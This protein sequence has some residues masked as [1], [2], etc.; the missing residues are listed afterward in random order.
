MTKPHISPSQMRMLWRCGEQYRRRYIEGERLPPGV[1]AVIGT[2]THRSIE[3]NLDHKMNTGELLEAD[4]VADAAAEGLN[5][6]WEQGV[7]LSDDEQAKGKGKVWGA[8]VDQAVALA[9]L[10]HA[11]LAP[12]IEP[13]GLEEKF[14]VSMDGYPFDLLGYIDIKEQGVIRDTKTAARA[15][16]QN[17]ADTS[18]QL[19]AYAYGYKDA[20]GELPDHL[21]L[22]YLVKTKTPKVVCYQTKRT[23]QDVAVLEAR[24]E[25]A[26]KVIESQVF[27][28]TSRSN[29]WCSERWCGYFSTCPYAKGR[30]V[31]SVLN[32]F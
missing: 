9:Q 1:A 18:E 11:E 25:Q 31:V 8:A 30:V 16:G 13:I 3:V 32:Q 20:E 14:V 28:P 4:Q 26:C 24:F 23:E 22:D 15:P 29:W 7:A 10:H 2:G 19:T 27:T 21:A 12:T 6:A 17:E 5:E